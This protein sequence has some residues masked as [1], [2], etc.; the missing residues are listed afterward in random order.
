M[1]PDLSMV[2][3]WQAQTEWSVELNSHHARAW[4]RVSPQSG[5]SAVAYERTERS[6][7]AQ[8]TARLK[9]RC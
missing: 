7:I 5:E 6:T 1:P 2:P 4:H 3:G 9:G 8:K